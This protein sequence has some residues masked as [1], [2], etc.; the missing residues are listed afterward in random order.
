MPLPCNDDAEA[1]ASRVI[2][3]THTHT[4]THTHPGWRILDHG[5][6]SSPQAGTQEWSFQILAE[7]CGKP[8]GS[9]PQGGRMSCSSLAQWIWPERA[10]LCP[11]SGGVHPAFHGQSL[12]PFPKNVLCEV[13]P[14][15]WHLNKFKATWEG[16]KGWREKKRGERKAKVWEKERGKECWFFF[17]WENLKELGLYIK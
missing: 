15:W 17:P 13:T 3:L 2:G 6:L 8:P 5:S 12:P 16:K 14:S 9:M 7:L 1:G 4:H 10:V 11:C